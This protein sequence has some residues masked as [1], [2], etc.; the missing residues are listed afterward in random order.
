M[1]VDVVLCLLLD[2]NGILFIENVGNFVCLVSF[3]FGEKYKVV[4][5][6]VI[7]GED[8]LLKYLYMF[9]VVL[10]MLFNKVDLLLYFNFDV[11]K[12]IVCVC[13]VNLEIEIIFIFVISGEG[14]D[15]WLN[16]LEIQ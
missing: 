10:L 3:D 5:F 2:D 4:V 7:E 11:E 12:C 1:I 13:E 16:W 9:V 6:F 8:K 15:Q 14:M